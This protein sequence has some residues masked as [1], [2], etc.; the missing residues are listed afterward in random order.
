MRKL[1]I[2]TVLLSVAILALCSPAIVYF[3]VWVTTGNRIANFD[4]ARAS[5]AFGVG[6]IMMF[7]A[8]VCVCMLED[9]K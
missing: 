6:V 2:A 3:C 4:H 7:P 5:A 1:K 9:G 8:V